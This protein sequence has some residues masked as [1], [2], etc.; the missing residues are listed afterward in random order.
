M[1]CHLH[2][3]IYRLLWS[4]NF[5]EMWK[6]YPQESQFSINWGE[7]LCIHRK[8]LT[9]SKWNC[10]FQNSMS[11]KNTT[12]TS[13]TFH[14][15]SFDCFI[16]GSRFISFYTCL[17]KLVVIKN[18]N[19]DVESTIYLNNFVVRKFINMYYSM[20][21]SLSMRKIEIY[22]IVATLNADGLSIRCHYNFFSNHD[23][24]K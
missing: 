5:L 12:S 7:W 23:V 20:R 22:G 17:L 15:Y 4:N 3:Y 1:F 10:V 14:D 9:L 24:L 13:K 21:K 18:S 11:K 6:M 16:A 19:T 8:R 2:V